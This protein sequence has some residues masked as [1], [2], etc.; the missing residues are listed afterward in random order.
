[1]RP[2]RRQAAGDASGRHDG[3]GAAE[4]AEHRTLEAGRTNQADLPDIVP[5]KTGD[6]AG[7]AGRAAQGPVRSGS[8]DAGRASVR[9]GHA[10]SAAGLVAAAGAAGPPAS[11]RAAGHVPCS[12][13]AVQEALDKGGTLLF[14]ASRHLY[15]ARTLQVGAAWA[16]IDANGFAVTFDGQAAAGSK[17][18]VQILNVAGGAH[19]ALVGLTLANGVMAGAEGARGMNGTNGPN[20]ADGTNATVAGAVGGALAIAAGATARAYDVTFQADQAVGGTGG[21]GSVGGV[22]GNG[23]NGGQAQ[24]ADI[25]SPASRPAAAGRAVPAPRRAR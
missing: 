14:G 22:A 2:G 5:A 11:V 24:G 6:R 16:V 20:G 3:A 10:A 7:W 13:S 9:A 23:G 25:Y 8:S 17:T 21:S 15:L 1:M 4:R 19:L 18:H 12:E